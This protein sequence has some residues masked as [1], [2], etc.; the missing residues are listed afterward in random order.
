MQENSWR[1]CG[2]DPISFWKYTPSET[3]MMVSA[4]VENRN[5]EIEFR[6]SLEARLCAIVLNANGVTKKNKKMFDLDDF[7]PVK[8]S[9]PM[10]PEQLE[11]IAKAAVMKMGGE[12]EYIV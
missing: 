11:Q 5:Q 4:S 8:K 1:F 9:K 6:S 12:V 7:M 10:T 2:I 3:S